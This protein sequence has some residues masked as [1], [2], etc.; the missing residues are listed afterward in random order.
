M[1]VSQSYIIPAMPEIYLGSSALI[2]R[3]FDGNDTI[4]EASRAGFSGVQLYID[5]K[6]QETKYLASIIDKIG[7]TGLGLV[8]HLPNTVGA[9]ERRI[10]QQITLKHPSA[11]TLIHYQ[12]T[13]VSPKIKG[14]K[15]GWENSITGP[16]TSKVESHIRETR[17]QAG[18]DR[19][20]F[21][22]D[23]GRQFYVENKSDIPRTASFI[24][25]QL[26]NLNPKRD[27]LHLADKTDWFL[28]FRNS[29]CVLG[30]G[31]M[32]EFLGDLNQF[33][34]VAVFEYENLDIALKSLSVLSN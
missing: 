30:S 33:S 7:E 34:G 28:S 15:V 8:L 22:Y 18:R 21:V 11:K 5:P 19:S 1:P 10:A 26:K 25:D 27:V 12:P 2:D 3:G 16:L 6:Y 14:V 9:T 4:R 23:M 31:V 13:T 17:T 20:F 29:M 24:R 32:K